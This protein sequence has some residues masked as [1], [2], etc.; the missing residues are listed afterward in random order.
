MYVLCL[1]QRPKSRH[2]LSTRR[3]AVGITPFQSRAIEVVDLEPP[4]AKMLR[5]LRRCEAGVFKRP[6]GAEAAALRQLIEASDDLMSPN[7]QQSLGIGQDGYSPY[8]EGVAEYLMHQTSMAPNKSRK[9]TTL[10]TYSS[11]SSGGCHTKSRLRPSSSQ[12]EDG[13]PLGSRKGDGDRRKSDGDRR[14]LLL[15]VPFAEIVDHDAHEFQVASP[16]DVVGP[17]ASVRSIGLDYGLDFITPT[18]PMRSAEEALVVVVKQALVA[19][20]LDKCLKTKQSILRL[21]SLARRLEGGYLEDGYHNRFHAADVTNRLACVLRHSGISEAAS[22]STS[23]TLHI[24]AAILAACA[25]DF[26][27]PQVRS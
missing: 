14:K 16:K 5:F 8:S 6:S 21:L 2:S 10:K 17:M 24:L 27:H 13:E 12:R 1:P 4:V 9:R 26:E 18:S 11:T 19:L 25:H 3:S 23:Q 20:N 22:R 15:E 7:L